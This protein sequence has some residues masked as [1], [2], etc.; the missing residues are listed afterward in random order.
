MDFMGF[1]VDKNKFGI[2]LEYCE[3]E[4]LKSFKFPKEWNIYILKKI[5]IEI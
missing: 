4:T 5:I 2:I 1:I 3:N